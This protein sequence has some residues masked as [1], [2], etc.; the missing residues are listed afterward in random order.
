MSIKCGDYN[1]RNMRQCNNTVVKSMIHFLFVKPA[2]SAHYIV[3]CNVNVRMLQVR[4]LGKSAP[5]SVQFNVIHCKT[6]Q[7]DTLQNI[8]VHNSLMQLKVHFSAMKCG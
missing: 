3:I 5:T 7:F 6:L 4:Q 8:V 1:E 2:Y